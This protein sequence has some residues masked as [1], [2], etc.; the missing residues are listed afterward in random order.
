MKNNA[1]CPKCKQGYVMG[2][3]GTVDGCDRCTGTV[4]DSEGNAWG[5]G[6]KTQTYQDVATGKVFTVSRRKALNPK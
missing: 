1:K 4:R 6:E 2:W 5:R 3:N